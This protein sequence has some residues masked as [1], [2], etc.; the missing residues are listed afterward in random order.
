MKMVR[1]FTAED[2]LAEDADEVE[3][4]SES[5]DE[6]FL[7]AKSKAIRMARYLHKC[8]TRARDV[9]LMNLCN[10]ELTCE[11]KKIVL[12]VYVKNPK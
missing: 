2:P 8:S 11:F 4:V 6:N 9:V 12:F 1:S 7:L 5:T 3:A 10:D